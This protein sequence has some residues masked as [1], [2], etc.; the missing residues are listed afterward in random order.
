M[1]SPQKAPHE[2]A[3]IYLVTQLESRAGMTA[4]SLLILFVAR[5]SLGGD[6]I[7]VL[8]KELWCVGAPGSACSLI[9]RLSSATVRSA[10][11]LQIDPGVT[12]D[13]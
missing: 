8:P 7:N 5:C 1:A 4:A 11:R 2:I 3:A 13:R 12:G 10:I 9:E 6:V